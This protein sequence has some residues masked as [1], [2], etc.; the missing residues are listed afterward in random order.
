MLGM[1]NFM[2]ILY[3]TPAID[4]QESPVPGRFLGS[5]FVFVLGMGWLANFFALWVSMMSRTR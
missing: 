2:V 4:G 5:N 3:T 1:S